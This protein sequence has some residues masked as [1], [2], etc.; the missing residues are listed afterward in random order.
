MLISA[1]ADIIKHSG[2]PIFLCA[3]GEC[4]DITRKIRHRKKMVK[5]SCNDELL[6][7]ENDF[8]KA[9]VVYTR[10]GEIFRCEHRIS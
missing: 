4:R 8:Q 10:Y 7:S 2:A 1:V 9:E 6:P 5:K 3:M